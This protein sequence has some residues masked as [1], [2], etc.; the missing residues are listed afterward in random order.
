MKRILFIALLMVVSLSLLSQDGK[1]RFI[2]INLSQ[3][4]YSFN[5]YSFNVSH[6]NDKFRFSSI[7]SPKIGIEYSFSKRKNIMH[8]IAVSYCSY[9]QVF[10]LDMPDFFESINTTHAIKNSPENLSDQFKR[11]IIALEYKFNYFINNKFGFNF[12][13]GLK[14]SQIKNYDDYIFYSKGFNIVQMTTE[15]ENEY[16]VLADLNLNKYKETLLFSL[17]FN[18]NINNKIHL[19]FSIDSAPFG[20]SYLHQYVKYD[21]EDIY[22]LSVDLYNRYMNVSFGMKYLFDISKEIEK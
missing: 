19:M 12:G 11:N 21:S 9:T 16:Y 22:D 17:G 5:K 8:G 4:V 3:S 6:E 13:V 14:Q 20:H 15:K 10:M 7:Y 1:K 18:Y 2:D